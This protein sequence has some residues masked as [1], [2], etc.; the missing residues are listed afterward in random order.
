MKPPKP[1]P[2]LNLISLTLAKFP[3]HAVPQ[4]GDALGKAGGITVGQDTFLVPGDFMDWHLFLTNSGGEDIASFK[5]YSLSAHHSGMDG[6]QPAVRSLCQRHL[7]NEIE[8][9]GLEVPKTLQP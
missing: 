1:G 3:P 6:L 2:S 7:R 8:Q 5:I 4:I 9:L